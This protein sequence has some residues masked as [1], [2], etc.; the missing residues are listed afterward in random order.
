M[1]YK[2][3]SVKAVTSSYKGCDLQ[4]RDT[5]ANIKNT[6]TKFRISLPRR[7][8]GYGGGKVD[9]GRDTLAEGTR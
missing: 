3:T 8:R 9:S 7:E 4:P 5:L 2:E 1:H 6:P